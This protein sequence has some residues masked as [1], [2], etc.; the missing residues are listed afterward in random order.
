MAILAYFLVSVTLVV[1]E[2]SISVQPADAQLPAP[3]AGL[4]SIRARLIGPNGALLV[5][6]RSNTELNAGILSAIEM[7]ELLA[8]A[9]ECT[10]L[11]AC[12]EITL[13]ASLGD[14]PVKVKA[15]RDKGGRLEVQLR[16][17]PF[18]DRAR[19]F[20]VAESFLARG[21]F[22]VGVEGPVAGKNIEAR[23]R[24]RPSEGPAIS[25]AA[26]PP[27]APGA[28]DA[29]PP[30]EVFGRWRRTTVRGGVV[31]LRPQVSGLSWDYEAP[32]GAGLNNNPGAVRAEGNGRADSQTVA[33]FGRIG[34]GDQERALTAPDRRT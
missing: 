1:A 7:P 32:Q 25:T 33:L 29:G 9:R 15:E 10:V 4:V 17:I 21:A 22:D 13:N 26:L 2:L 16:E 14:A 27:P 34:A 18:P 11:L 24:E 12:T 8:L 3:S 6:P 5:A 19:L 28:G 20:E 30:V 23:V 31:V